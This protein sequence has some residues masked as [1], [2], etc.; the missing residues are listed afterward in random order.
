MNVEHSVS[1][2][3]LRPAGLRTAF[4]AL[5]LQG[6]GFVEDGMLLR[7]WTILPEARTN[8]ARY[9]TGLGLGEA[10]APSR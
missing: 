2:L 10:G 5:F 9:R 3:S 7:P 6:K 4:S 8:G 1:V